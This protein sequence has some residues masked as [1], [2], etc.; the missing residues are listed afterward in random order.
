VLPPEVLPPGPRVT[1]YNIGRG[2]KVRGAREHTL[3]RVATTIAVERPDVVALQEVHRPDVPA[4]VGFLADRHDLVYEHVFGETI[5]AEEIARR[6]YAGRVGAYGVALLARRPLDDV[7]V[8]RLP[9]GGEARVAVV[10]RTSVG[11]VDATV[12]ATHVDTGARPGRRDT[13]TRAVLTLADEVAGPVVVLGDLNQEPSTVA[14][15]LAAVGSSLV[16]AGDPDAPTLGLWTIDH[17][18]V[19]GGL[20]AVGA[21]VGEAGVSDHRPLTVALRR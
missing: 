18:L 16:R 15:S 10:A 1:T 9:G 19:G 5:P 7:R 4:I 20:Q 6:R 3:D 11:G 12:I 14:A 13:Q 2:A 21:K 8:V 17:V